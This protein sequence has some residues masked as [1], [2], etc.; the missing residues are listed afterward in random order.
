M[1]NPNVFPPDFWGQFLQ[2]SLTALGEKCFPIYVAF[3][4][5]L[6][7]VAGAISKLKTKL[8][9]ANASE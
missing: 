6:T 1:E 3:A 2:C 5:R 9:E 8:R 7:P 4:V